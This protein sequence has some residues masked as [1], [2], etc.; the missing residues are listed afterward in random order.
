M[1]DLTAIRAAIVAKLRAV[2]G[3]GQV[4]DYERYAKAEKDFRGLYQDGSRL[5][6]WHVRRVKARETSPSMSRRHRRVT[7]QIRGFMS[8]DD[9]A[10]SEM[11][12]DGLIE[13]VIDAFRGDENLGGV[14]DATVEPD[15]DG[16]AGIQL[17]DAGPVMF[18][19]VL[20]HAATLSITTIN[21]L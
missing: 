7:W 16:L 17:D 19:G 4:H 9:A 2:P 5:L 20:C 21:Y 13:S 11:A 14:V 15:G 6:G 18:A 12:F 1:S 3:I 10:A 8:F